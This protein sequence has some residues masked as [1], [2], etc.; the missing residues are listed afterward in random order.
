MPVPGALF[1]R[2]APVALA[3][4]MLGACGASPAPRLHTLT[5][6]PADPPAGGAAAVLVEILPVT[7]PQR[8]ERDDIVLGAGGPLT[9]VPGERWAGPL[10]DE[11]RQAVADALWRQLKAVDVYQA[12]VSE[13]ATD[14][15]LYR[16]AVRVERF[17][18]IPGEAATIE[19]GWTVR[20]LPQGAAV[21][22]RAARV[23]PLPEASVD[24]AVR[25]LGQGTTQVAAALAEGVARVHQG[26]TPPCP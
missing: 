26:K 16:L 8:L 12:P 18:A 4:L 7:V 20:R 5:L 23:V 14:L 24:G 2:L 10:P 17:Q 22:C 13:R 6:P 11:I 15:P 9:T 21:V 3:A 1:V 19:I 25:A